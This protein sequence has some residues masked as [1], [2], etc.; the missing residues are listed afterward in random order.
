[1]TPV[2][3]FFLLDRE[4]FRG[5]HHASNSRDGKEL[6]GKRRGYIWR[7]GEK[8]NGWRRGWKEG[9]FCGYKFESMII[10]SWRG[11][12]ENCSAGDA[13]GS[14]W[15]RKGW[16]VGGADSDKGTGTVQALDL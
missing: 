15:L 16:T 7:G 5:E 4:K 1:M 12:Y 14:F 11:L 6:T 10:W 2:G 8:L 9:M 13:E 3:I